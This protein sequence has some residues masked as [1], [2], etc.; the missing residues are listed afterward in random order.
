MNK[1][2]KVVLLPVIVGKCSIMRHDYGEGKVD[3]NRMN[4]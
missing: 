2:G 1:E 3:R 4:L